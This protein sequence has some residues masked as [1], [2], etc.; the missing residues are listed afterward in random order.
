MAGMKRIEFY[1]TING[2]SPVEEFLETL[3]DNQARKVLWVLRLI[4]ELD[5]IPSNYFNKLVNTDN[6]WEMRVQYGGNI[7]RLLGFFDDSE[8]IV[9]THGFQK[10]T[11][12]TP[13][14]HI[15]LAESRKRDYLSRR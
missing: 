15:E 13:K 4:R 11:Q 7:F 6:I 9:L 10:K 5:P 1:R 12:K 3:D 2:A 14:Q 8:L